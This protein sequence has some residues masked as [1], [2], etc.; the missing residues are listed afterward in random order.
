MKTRRRVMYIT[1]LLAIHL[2]LNS[3][4][5][6]SID[7]Q[8]NRDGSGKLTMEYRISRLLDNLGMLDGNASMP[9]LPVGRT[10]WERTV[11]RIPGTKLSSY[12]SNSQ[13]QDTVVKVVIDFDNEETLLQLL[14]PSAEQVSINRQGQS[15]KFDIIL[16]N[17]D[18]DFDKSMM[19]LVRIFSDNY[20]FS[21][22]FSGPGNSTLTITDGNGHTM[23]VPQNAKT[24]QSGRRVSYSTGIMDLFDLDSGLGFKFTW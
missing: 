5:G 6:L 14:D 22:S 19:D 17:D 2:T 11:E 10:D 3:C 24:I 15:G 16:L 13:A 23:P 7:I 1:I 21:I 8:M 18:Y 4:I 9:A 20:E 12:S